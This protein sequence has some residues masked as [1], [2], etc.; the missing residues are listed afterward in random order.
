MKEPKIAVIGAGSPQWTPRLVT[1]ITLER[2]L[3]GGEIML[4]DINPEA[5]DVLTTVCQRIHDE[6][7]GAFAVAK[8]LDLDEAL[9][10]ADFVIVSITTGG[11][12]A[13]RADIEVPERYHCFQTVADTVG[14]GGLARALRN[15]PVFVGFT[16]A[17]ERMCPR[18]WMLNVSNPL[19]ALTRAVE[20]ISAL[21]AVGVC[22]GVEEAVADY[23]KLME[24]EGPVSYRVAGIDHCSWLLDFKVGETDMLAAIRGRLA[25]GWSFGEDKQE[26]VERYNACLKLY[27]NLGYLPAIQARHIV[28]FFP[29]FLQDLEQVER[30]NLK[31]TVYE[32]RVRGRTWHRERAL[33]RAT[34]EEDIPR[35]QSREAVAPMIRAMVTGRRV[36]ESL[37]V[38]NEGQIPNLPMDAVVETRTVIDGA[39]VHPMAAG[40]LPPELLA[41]VEPHVLRQEMTVECALTGD[42]DQALAILATDPLVQDLDSARQML[43][44][45]LEANRQYL[46]QFFPR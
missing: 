8:T 41:V 22:H 37:N 12:A 29:F 40:P 20:K 7:D 43:R 46:P 2:E 27:Q 35:A 32:D 3:P 44:E 21:R 36:V 11:E 31:R 33:K 38:R 39:G 19:S 23:V 30:Y 15:I 4:H 34:G 5:L 14:P 28:E 10:G 17:M 45:L 42:W 16:R 1:D 25:D 24:A 13:M 6:H 18:A 26:L 9:E